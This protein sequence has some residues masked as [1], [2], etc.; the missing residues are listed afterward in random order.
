MRTC[1]HCD[2]FQLKEPGISNA[3]WCRRYAPSGIDYKVITEPVD[4]LNVFP[5][6]DDGTAE[7]CGDYKPTTGDTPD[8]I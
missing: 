7:D 2:Y 3:G 1:W 4:A 8:S 6:I 5:P